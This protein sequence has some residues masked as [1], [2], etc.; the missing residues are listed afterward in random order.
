MRV[1]NGIMAKNAIL[2]SNS[3]QYLTLSECNNHRTHEL[4]INLSD[5]V[6]ID[7]ILVSNQEDF[8]AQLNNVTFYGS[9]EPP[10]NDVWIKLG[11]IS[12]E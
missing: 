10:Q 1:S 3:E 4:V 2:S 8:S 6:Q 7:T 9:V 11:S 12:P 5:D